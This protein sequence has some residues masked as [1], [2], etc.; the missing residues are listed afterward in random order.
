MGTTGRSPGVKSSS[1]G[2]EDSGGAKDRGGGKVPP[3]VLLSMC[4]VLDLLV[5]TVDGIFS[6]KYLLRMSDS[7][8]FALHHLAYTSRTCLDMRTKMIKIQSPWK[9]TMMV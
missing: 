4:L 3:P 1:S 6:P 2:L 5:M 9:A 7:L 8:T